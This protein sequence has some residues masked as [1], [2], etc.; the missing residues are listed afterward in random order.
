MNNNLLL[1]AEFN[2]VAHEL[3]Y[4]SPREMVANS[5]FPQTN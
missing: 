1:T 5:P 3:F 2:I 4:M